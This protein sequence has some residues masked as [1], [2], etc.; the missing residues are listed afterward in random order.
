[1]AEDAL[2]LPETVD[3]PS[4]STSPCRFL[5]NQGMYLFSDG[6][7][8]ASGRDDSTIYWCTKSMKGYGPDDEP[9]ERELCG[10]P[11][12]SCYESI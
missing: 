8:R 3:L 4:R 1:M 6:K 11:S 10:N 9:V 2:D 5:R 12:R 7:T